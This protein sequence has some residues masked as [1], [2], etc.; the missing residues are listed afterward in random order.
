VTPDPAPVE[1][2]GSA[3]APVPAP[4]P[5]AEAAPPPPAL[6]FSL[7]VTAFFAL[8]VAAYIVG[9]PVLLPLLEGRATALDALDEP[10][11]ALRRLVEREMDLREALQQA[12]AWEWWLY[13]GGGSPAEATREAREWYEELLEVDDSARARLEHAILA[14]ESAGGPG[15]DEALQQWAPLTEPDE[16]LA[17]WVQAAY[18]G[19]PLS[20]PEA[21][22]LVADIR[23]TL[24]RTWFADILVLRLAQRRGD[25]ETAREAYAAIARR[26][27][28]LSARLRLLVASGIAVIALGA[29]IGAGA[30]WRR[31]GRG[32]L[33]GAAPLPPS[34]PA[35]HGWALFVRGTGAPQVIIVTFF[36]IVR[37]ETPLE[38]LVGMAADLALFAWVW[39]YLRRRRL[40]PASAF[41]LRTLRGSG[42][43]LLGITVI[44]VALTLA[45]DILVDLAAPGLGMRSHWSDGFPEDLLWT[46]P[47]PLAVSSV[48]AIVWAPV[49]EE[50]TF[51][52]LLY[53]TLRRSLPLWSAATLSALVFVLPH[54]YGAAGSVSVFCSGL[55]WAVAYE[56]TRSLWPP[57]LAHSAN[58]AI[59]TVWALATL[60][61]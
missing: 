42:T 57:I 36:Y 6:R 44:L 24:G 11:R 30:A 45:A 18:L 26:G 48:D 28:A 51:R 29:V 23:A 21:S 38:P 17:G 41:G 19:A 4:A 50:L 55:L 49:V 8:V 61:W 10:A 56:R 1:P 3:G 12:P 58:N 5:P 37:R 9:W 47:W 54:Q 2:D 14:G 59:S 32:L 60:R 20:R 16:R 35:T 15:V 46:S 53:G 40:E 22:A 39:A 34:W 43:R 52:G 13:T 31:P 25:D 7:V 27:A 33:V